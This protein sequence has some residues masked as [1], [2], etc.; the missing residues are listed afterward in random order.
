MLDGREGVEVDV[1]SSG[2]AGLKVKQRRNYGDQVTAGENDKQ[3][4][5]SE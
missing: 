4:R 1:E 3:G 2:G 5:Q